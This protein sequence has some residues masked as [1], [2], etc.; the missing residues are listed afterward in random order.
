MLE[1]FRK[2]L[3]GFILVVVTSRKKN[4]SRIPPQMPLKRSPEKKRQFVSI[5]PQERISPGNQQFILKSQQEFV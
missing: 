5:I 3:H 2:I 1:L 4:P